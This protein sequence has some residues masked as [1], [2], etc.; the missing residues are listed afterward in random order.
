MDGHQDPLLS[1]RARL[2]VAAL[3]VKGVGDINRTKGSLGRG[4]I[5]HE[6]RKA[7]AHGFG[8]TKPNG[9]GN[10]VEAEFPGPEE[11]CGPAEFCRLHPGARERPRQVKLPALVWREA[12]LHL[13]L[14]EGQHGLIPRLTPFLC[15]QLRA[16]M[17][18]DGSVHVDLM[19][20]Q[21]RIEAEAGA[22]KP[23]DVLPV[24]V[25]RVASL[26]K[27]CLSVQQVEVLKL[28]RD[29]VRQRRAQDWENARALDCSG[30]N[31]VGA[32]PA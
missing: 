7:R 11:R 12:A 13:E 29:N 10:I 5:S 23:A 15:H 26:R 17:V 30:E 19:Q 3:P 32:T 14:P 18:R 20:A 21:R 27:R 28:G 1:F 6:S 31:P 2:G 8:G 16:K 25:E 24:G 4:D 9:G 22:V